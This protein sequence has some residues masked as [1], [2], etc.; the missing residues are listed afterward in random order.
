MDDGESRPSFASGRQNIVSD[1][2]QVASG[3]NPALIMGIVCFYNAQHHKYKVEELLQLLSKYLEV[4]SKTLRKGPVLEEELKALKFLHKSAKVHIKLGD[5]AA[6]GPAGDASGVSARIRSIAELGVPESEREA[7][8]PRVNLPFTTST[9]LLQNVTP[10]SST[11]I[12]HPPVS[13]STSQDGPIPL[14]VAH[15]SQ[16][17]L[18]SPQTATSTSSSA[19]I[20]AGPNM[21]GASAGIHPG[22]AYFPHVPCQNIPLNLQASIGDLSSGDRGQMFFS[23]FNGVNIHSQLETFRPYHGAPAFLST[24]GGV[25]LYP[26]VNGHGN[27]SVDAHG[28]GSGQAVGLGL[29]LSDESGRE[30]QAVIAASLALPP[31]LPSHHSLNTRDQVLTNFSQAVNGISPEQQLAELPFINSLM[32][33]LGPIPSSGN[34]PNTASSEN[35]GL[36][37]AFPHAATHGLPEETVALSRGSGQALPV[38]PSVIHQ[39][40][41]DPSMLAIE[42]PNNSVEGQAGP[43]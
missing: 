11:T 32:D 24:G 7:K 1:H 22:Q 36:D 2:G 28:T 6:A 35:F 19:T 34:M 15:H 20:T 17:T 29:D 43:T 8:R 38:W 25:T 31:S 26:T 42:G 13:A 16:T 33:S 4:E 27:G 21:A 23:D 41:P 14:P 12:F 30:F 18:F 40:A 5:R 39:A 37:Q 10:S 9:P 3:F